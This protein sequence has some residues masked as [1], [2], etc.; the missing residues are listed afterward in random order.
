MLE[1]MSKYHLSL[2]EERLLVIFLIYSSLSF[3]DLIFLPQQQQQQ[4]IPN[5]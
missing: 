2:F 4:P 1:P 5:L 3:S